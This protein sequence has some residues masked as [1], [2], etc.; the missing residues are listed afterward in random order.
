MKFCNI[1]IHKW[2]YSAPSITH[3]RYRTCEICK[4]Q[5]VKGNDILKRIST[6]WTIKNK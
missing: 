1:G 2:K 5:Q 4:N 6:W 3:L